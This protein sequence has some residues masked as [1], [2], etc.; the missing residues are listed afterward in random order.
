[1]VT[2]QSATCSVCGK[3]FTAKDANGDINPAEVKA[4]VDKLINTF[5]EG[6]ANIT[7][8]LR[9]IEPD[10]EKAYVQNESKTLVPAMEDACNSI[11]KVLKQSA[12]TIENENLYAKAEQKHDEFQ[13]KYNSDASASAQQCAASHEKESQS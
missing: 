2:P 8:A 10:A 5:N 7:A 1:M 9:K 13:T 11:D 6:S 12:S 4:A 3:V